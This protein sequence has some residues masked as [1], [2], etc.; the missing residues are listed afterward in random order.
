MIKISSI[1]QGTVIDTATHKFSWAID[2]M[3]GQDT[4]SGGAWDKTLVQEW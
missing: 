3:I 1:K 2:G 4:N